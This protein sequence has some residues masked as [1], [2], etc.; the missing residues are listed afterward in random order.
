VSPMRRV[1]GALFGQRA[2]YVA[3]VILA[4][5]AVHFFGFRG[6]RFFM[7]PSGSME[8]TLFPTDHIVTLREGEY[9]RGDIVVALDPHGEGNIVKRITGVS[10]DRLSVERGGLL[11]NSA[12]AS[13]PYMLEPMVYTMPPT[14]PVPSGQV[15]LMGD[16]RNYSDDSSTDGTTIPV[17]D[18]VGRVRFIYYPYDRWGPVHFYPLLNSR[19]E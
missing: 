8:N 1:A 16:N 2:G 9:R 15:F 19:G 6:M 14:H 4:L 5:L 18:I 12:Y 11:I 17:E 7:V 3:I 13:E 10:G